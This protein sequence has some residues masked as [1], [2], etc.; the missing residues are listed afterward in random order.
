[1]WTSDEVGVNS[2]KGLARSVEGVKTGAPSGVAWVMW[3]RGE[4]EE[5]YFS[6]RDEMALRVDAMFEVLRW[7]EMYLWLISGL[8]E[9]EFK[10]GKVVE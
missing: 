6:R 3:M 1:M 5:R 4:E 7:P 9:L 2:G 8:L 10:R